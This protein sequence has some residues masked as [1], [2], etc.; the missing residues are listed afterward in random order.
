MLGVAL[1]GLAACQTTPATASEQPNGS[2]TPN[3]ALPQGVAPQNGTP[4]G[5]VAT[6]SA[7]TT[8]QRGKLIGMANPASVHCVKAGGKL[9]IRT[10]ASGGQYGVC[11]MPDGNSC[12]EWSFFRTGQCKAESLKNH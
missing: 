7:A 1:L 2:A 11:H 6:T 8:P 9:E 5:N 3:A 10:G 12:E 4:T